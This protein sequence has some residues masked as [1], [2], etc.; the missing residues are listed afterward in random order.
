MCANDDDEHA[1]SKTDPSFANEFV[2]DRIVDMRED[3]DGNT[4]FKIK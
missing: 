4:L 3:N 2:M 1:L